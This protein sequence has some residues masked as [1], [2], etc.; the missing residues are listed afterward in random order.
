MQGQDTSHSLF[1]FAGELGVR[2][3]S[4]LNV[5]SQLKMLGFNKTGPAHI[6]RCLAYHFLKR[7]IRLLLA[8]V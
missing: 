8:S 6:Q 3:V 2:M 5:G 7:Y 4:P 1:R